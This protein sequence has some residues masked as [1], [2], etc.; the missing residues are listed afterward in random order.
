MS[1]PPAPDPGPADAGPAAD[2]A[3]LVA[4]AHDRHHEVTIVGPHVLRVTGRFG[5]PTLGALELMLEAPAPFAVHAEGIEGGKS[6]MCLWDGE[7]LYAILLGLGGRWEQF[8]TAGVGLAGIR[9]SWRT[10]A[11]ARHRVPRGPLVQPI[12]EAIALAESW[13]LPT[14]ETHQPAPPPRPGSGARTSSPPRKA[15]RAAPATTRTPRPP[16]PK[17]EPKPA[18]PSE[19]IRV[20]PTCFVAL[21]A[22]GIC[23]YCA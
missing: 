17:A 23:D 9:D 3:P 5:D 21:P 14:P 12:P 1:T 13:G 8:A 22:T 16:K 18:R 10:G 15:D 20:C 7:H 19:E 2:L 11:R 6:A 4:S